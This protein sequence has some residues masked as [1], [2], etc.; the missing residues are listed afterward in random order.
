METI[1]SRAHTGVE[2]ADG[3]CCDTGLTQG[4]RTAVL[5]SA[6]IGA[7]HCTGL[8]YREVDRLDTVDVRTVAGR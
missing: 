4:S 3:N 7:L 1:V 6:L 5:L 2:T 8:A